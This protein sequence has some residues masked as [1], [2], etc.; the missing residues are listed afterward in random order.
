MTYHW[1][2]G[3]MPGYFPTL[4]EVLSE[5]D[6][7]GKQGNFLA[8]AE[9][10][11][12]VREL[13]LKNLIIP[14]TGDFAGAKALPAIADF[15]RKHSLTVSAFYASNVEQYLFDNQVF[16]DF[17]KNV[18]KL[19]VN[20]QSVFIRSVLSRFGHPAMAPGHQFAILLQKIPVFI[21]EFDAGRYGE[22]YTLVNSNYIAPRP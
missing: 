3:Y 1:S 17:A 20:D 12:F 9:E 14:V 11:R 4:K 8:N 18:K 10:Y 5:T 16:D 15:L 6:L 7:S 19:P 13:Q 22:Y 21:K 2:G